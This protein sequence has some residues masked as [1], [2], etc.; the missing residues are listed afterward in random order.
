FK[1]DGKP[2]EQLTVEIDVPGARENQP[3]DSQVAAVRPMELAL[4]GFEY[5]LR[6][7]RGISNPVF[8]GLATGP[9]VVEQEPNNK[10]EAAQRIS[11]PC[12]FVG[13]FYPQNDTDWVS[14][15]AKQGDT[16]WIEVF[17]Q[18]LGLPT[19]PFVVVQ[20]VTSN[21]NG[22]EKASDVLELADAD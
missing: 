16:Y 18:R 12:E 5:R 4:E 7:S 19:D 20:R 11:L 22:N 13:Q 10:P 15:Q 2:L 21:E 17:S 1:F 6:T 9:V 14:F 3:G 8:V